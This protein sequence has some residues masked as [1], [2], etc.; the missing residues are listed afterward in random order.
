MLP[1]FYKAVEDSEPQAFRKGKIYIAQRN[2][3]VERI[4]C[5]R[6]GKST[7]VTA[8]C[9]FRP[10]GTC[11]AFEIKAFEWIMESPVC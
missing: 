11:I 2:G 3:S 8:P 10:F 4:L 6:G 1:K 5:V 9:V 7:N